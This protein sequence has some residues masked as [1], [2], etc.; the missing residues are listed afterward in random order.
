MQSN[1]WIWFSQGFLESTL[2]LGDRLSKALGRGN[3]EAFLDSG[4]RD[5]GVVRLG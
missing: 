4:A 2:S 5:H 3:P 1:H